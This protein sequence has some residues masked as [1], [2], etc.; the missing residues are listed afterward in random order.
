M[1]ELTEFENKL[2]DTEV[3]QYLTTEHQLEDANDNEESNA[4]D[5]LHNKLIAI[6]DNV[7]KAFAINREDLL[8]RINVKS[9]NYKRK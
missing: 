9:Q 4:V 7:T 6:L 8:E 2:V 5:Y 3:L 1:N